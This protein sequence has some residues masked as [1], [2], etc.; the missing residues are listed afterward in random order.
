MFLRFLFVVV[1]FHYLSR[2]ELPSER[3]TFLTSYPYTVIAHI[4]YGFHIHISKGGGG[5]RSK[6]TLSSYRPARL[7]KYPSGYEPL[8]FQFFEDFVL[9][10]VL[11]SSVTGR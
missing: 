6:A 11:R 8:L 10:C 9:F 1:S 7:C 5:G 2:V 3:R 4:S